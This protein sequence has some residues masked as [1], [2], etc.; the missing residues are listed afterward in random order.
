VS[1]GAN[2]GAGPEGASGSAGSAGNAGVGGNFGNG[3]SGGTVDIG[4]SG[5]R[6]GSGNLGD[7]AV[8]D[9]VTQ[10]A[11]NKIQP[12]D[13][14]FVVDNSGSMTAE[15]GFVQQNL[16][17]FSRGITMTGIDV[18]VVLISSYP[19]RGNGICI[20]P[21]LGAGGCP[22]TDSR[23][24]AFLHVNQEVGST[25]GLQLILST[26]QQWQASMRAGASKHF[27]VITDDNSRMAAADFNTQLLA[28]NPYF[29]GYKLHAVFAPTFP[30]DLFGCLMMPPVDPCC[31]LAAAQGTVYQELIQMTGAV[32]GNLCLQGP[33]FTQVFNAVA[34]KV[35]QGSQ[36]ACEWDIPQQQDGGML[37]PNKVNVKLTNGGQER[38]LG[39]VGSVGECANFKDA[40]YYD[41]PA[42]PTRV[43]ACPD[44]CTELKAGQSVKIN[45]QFGCTSKPP[46][47]V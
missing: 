39:K 8:C 16:N 15:A 13:I 26:Y 17:S 33:G 44:V 47:P 41:N 43:L 2:G 40:W 20:D 14:I 37:D 22:T 12:A 5:G 1:Y 4:G 21:P 30:T 27:V 11:I 10:E 46:V 29:Q 24:P 42:A 9:G 38:D 28:L 45:I 32:A 31:G 34:A 19:G 7:G 35:V 6:S 23:A 25:N 36:I 3:G 18:Q